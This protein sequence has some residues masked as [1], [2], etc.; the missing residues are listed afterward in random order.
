VT[1]YNIIRFDHLLDRQ[2][3]WFFI[4]QTVVGTVVARSPEDALKKA[5]RLGHSAPI[6]E[7]AKKGTQ[8]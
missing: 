7:Q 2:D 5:K 1:K 4:R 6:I 3:T 8:Q